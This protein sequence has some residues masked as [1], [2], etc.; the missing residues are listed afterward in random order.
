VAKSG[1]NGVMPMSP[2]RPVEDK[3]DHV[4]AALVG[5]VQ[6]TTDAGRVEVVVFGLRTAVAE[7]VPGHLVRE[8][9]GEETGQQIL[10]VAGRPI[11]AI[12]A[13]DSSERAGSSVTDLDKKGAVVIGQR[14]AMPRLKRGDIVLGERRVEQVTVSS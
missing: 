8:G 6:G 7:F 3:P 10:A 2:L 4:P 13:E 1:R 11:G 9:P 14:H 5:Q 12:E